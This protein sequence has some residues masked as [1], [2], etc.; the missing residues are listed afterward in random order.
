MDM[1][2]SLSRAR[3]HGSAKEGAAGHWWAERIWA[4]ALI[5]LCLWFVASAVTMVGADHATF[6]AWVGAHGNPVLLILLTIAMYHHGQMGLTVVIEDY[7]HHET[8]SFVG[9]LLVKMGAFFFAAYTIFSIV[10][11]TFGD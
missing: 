9:L 8:A 11:L 5:P 3:G 2:S 10:R 6:K 7:V 1:R 4:I